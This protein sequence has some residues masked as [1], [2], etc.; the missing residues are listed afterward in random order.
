MSMPL[1]AT[2]PLDTLWAMEPIAF[3]R[4]IVAQRE[5]SLAQMRAP[6]G[7]QS[8]IPIEVSQGVAVVDVLGPLSKRA[9]MYSAIFNASSYRAIQEAIDLAAGDEAVAAILLVID[10]PGGSV[11]GLAEVADAIAAARKS[12]TVWAQVAGMGASAAYYLASQAEKIFAQRMD[13]VGSI[14][15]RLMLYDF[16]GLFAKEGIEAIDISTGPYKAAGAMGTKITDDHKVYFQSIVDAFFKDFVGAIVRGRNMTEEA[17][18]KAADGRIFTAAD[19]KQMGLIDGIQPLTQTLGQL[20]DMAGAKLKTKGR[21]TMSETNDKPQAAG[22]EDMKLCCPGADN[23][24]LCGQ[25]AKKATIDQAQSAWMEEQ[26]RRLEQQAEETKTREKE[27]AELKEKQTQSKPGVDALGT[28]NVSASGSEG[29]P[30]AA[31]NEAIAEQTK[32]GKSRAD[33]VRAV[34]RA[35]PEL[36]QEYLAACNRG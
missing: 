25:L 11:D 13:M 6:T 21:V 12:K 14:G 27:L 32:Q 16:S 22:Y 3:D 34:V 8:S 4:M 26:G 19:A 31:W 2:V 7:V 5:A 18:L 36:H 17:I 28:G 35:N 9:S 24:F 23:D 10:S 30:V 29:D 20:V 1:S 15:T 33:A